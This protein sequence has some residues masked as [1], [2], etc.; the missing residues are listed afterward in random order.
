MTSSKAF[1]NKFG[2]QKDSKAPLRCFIWLSTLVSSLVLYF[3]QNVLFIS[4]EMAVV[5]FNCKL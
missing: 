4:Q 2:E 1:A 5:L 3:Y